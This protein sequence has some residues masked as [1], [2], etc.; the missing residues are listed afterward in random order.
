MKRVE[1]ELARAAVVLASAAA[2]L[3]CGCSRV[4]PNAQTD[5]GPPVSAAAV[6]PPASHARPALD[7]SVP[8][9]HLVLPC[10]VLAEQ[11]APT[12][13]LDA[14]APIPLQPNDPARGWMTLA[15]GDDV[16]VT[17]PRTAREIEF[18]GPALVH[19]CVAGDEAWVARGTFR[20]SRGS[21]ETPGAHEWVVTPFG[22]VRYGAAIVEVV[23]DA[24]SARASLKGG[25]ASVLSEG[26]T[27]W[28]VL[29]AGTTRVL[30]GAA[31]GDAGAREA[32]AHCAKATLD[33]K[34]LQDQLLAPGAP[35]S[36]TYGD[37]ATRADDANVLARGLCAMAGLRGSGAATR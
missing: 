25:S 29:A 21:G 6:A 37:L 34:A 1:I 12:I 10:R 8:R 26:A 35:A 24:S 14:S 33:A 18:L 16:T 28:D 32:G 2:V 30:K 9:Q 3:A 19:P 31:L 13:S 27:N 23:V 5:A 7:A 11:G 17:M 36:A 15:P 20:G 4:T 22:V